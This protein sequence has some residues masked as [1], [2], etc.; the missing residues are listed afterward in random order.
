MTEQ[1]R[2]L[3]TLRPLERRLLKMR[4]DG[5]SVEEIA[6]R[7]KKSPTFVERVIEWTKIPRS[8]SERDDLLTP[9][10]TRVLAL[11]AQG[12]DRATIAR[13]F[14]R[15]ERFIRQVEGLAH[16]RKGLDLMTEAADL[17]R[18]AEKART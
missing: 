12:E 6:S 18:Q 13:R 10:Q 2:H 7:I 14:K 5:K 16:F 4:T 17:A 15:T 9:L 3:D 8:G 11:A 1:Q